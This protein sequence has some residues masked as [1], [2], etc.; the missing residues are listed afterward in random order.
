MF[1][2]LT[3]HLPA[4]EKAERFGSWVVDRES[5]GTMDDPIQMPYVDYVTT[6]TEVDQAIYGF[7]DEHPEY[8]LTHYRDILE[9]NGLE[10]DSQAMSEA[11]VSKLSGQ[12][13]MALL[14]GAVRAE[15]FCDGALLGFF[16][17]GSIRR[18]LVRLREIDEQDGDE[19]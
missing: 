17:D 8:K 1:E 10:W 3:K 9:H 2:G 18:W 19:G 7:V 12:A 13:V 14:L 4:I 5:K 16:E 15:R 6:V 11:D